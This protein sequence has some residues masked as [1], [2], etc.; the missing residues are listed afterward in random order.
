MLVSPVGM[1]PGALY[2]ALRVAEPARVDLLLVVCSQ[3]TRPAIAEACRAA[4]YGGEV[5]PV[6]L[7]DPLGGVTELDRRAGEA[8]PRLV[9]AAEVLVNITGGT[10]LMGVLVER[11]AKQ[12]P[13]TARVHR[14]ALVDRRSPGEQEADPYRPGEPCWLDD[15]PEAGR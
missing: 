13:R 14:F 4:G 9:D 11:I 7:D 10:T 15:P 3:Q 12:A 2:S 6:V 8:K 5:V 1:R